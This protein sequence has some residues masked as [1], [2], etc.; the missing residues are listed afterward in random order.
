MNKE[1]QFLKKLP[2]LPDEELIALINE[3][4]G[5][6]KAVA[7]GGKRTVRGQDQV[8]RRLEAIASELQAR[9]IGSEPWW[10]GH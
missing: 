3:Q 4:R 1:I 5:S 10:E 9:G 7:R 6:S 8:S 2:L